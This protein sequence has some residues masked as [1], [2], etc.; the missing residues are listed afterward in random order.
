VSAAI[1]LDAGPLGLLTNPKL[2]AQPQA[3]RAW[4]ASLRAAG[5][6]VIVPEIA[7]YE[8]R[9]ELLRIQSQSALTNLNAFGILLEYLPL[10]TAAM[11]R[12]AE[13][14]ALARSTG[15]PTASDAAL[16]PGG[17]GPGVERAYTH[18]D[19][20]PRPPDALCAGGLVVR[21]SA[22]NESRRLVPMQTRCIDASL[23]IS[24]DG[25]P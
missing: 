23:R 11:R 14:W 5:R 17:A 4:I 12:A 8:V 22:V 16:D 9:W 7:D 10:T 15:Q 21:H 18:R 1:V 24:D 19:G 13:L 3:C 20:E 25:Q 2:S 6:R